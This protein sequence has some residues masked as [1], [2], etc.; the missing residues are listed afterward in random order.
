MLEQRTLTVEAGQTQRVDI[1]RSSGH[2][3]RGQVA[4]IRSTGAPG[5]Y[6]YAYSSQT[7]NLADMVS[8]N[9]AGMRSGRERPFD[10]VTCGEDGQFQLARLEPGDYTV[11]ALV[12]VDPDDPVN[13]GRPDFAGTAN[14][15]IASGASPPEPLKIELQPWAVATNQ[16]A[17]SRR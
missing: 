3:I 7:N 16:P 17:A 15:S 6:V 4:G 5:A 13:F 10:L 9:L 1:V 8:G 2:S 11:V 14:V 12:V